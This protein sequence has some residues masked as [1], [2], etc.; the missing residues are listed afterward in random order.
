MVA[1]AALDDLCNVLECRA[2]LF[3]AVVAEGH[4]VGQVGLVAS[5]VHSIRELLH[6][7]SMSFLLPQEG[8]LKHL[9]LFGIWAA[10]IQDTPSQLHLVLLVGN[11]SLQEHDALRVLGVLNRLTH[12]GRFVVE[13]SLHKALDM[14]DLVF[15]DLWAGLTELTIRLR[16]VVEV[17]HVVVAVA[18]QRQCTS[19][20]W[21]VLQLVAQH[22]DSLLVLLLHDVLIDRLGHLTLLHRC[23]D[24]CTKSGPKWHQ[25]L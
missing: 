6:G 21:E 13:P 17:L 15:V 10:L 14:V 24:H 11:G 5:R 16:C 8:A 7:I 23:S 22:L 2:I 20:L 1:N 25:T 12:L 19:T 3:C 9:A 18:Q 4:V